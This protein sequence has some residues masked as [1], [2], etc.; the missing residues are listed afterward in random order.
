M[1]Y[2]SI[3]LETT[4]LDPDTCQILEIG[5]VFN[6][7]SLPLALCPIF[8]RL[9]W[10]ASGL[11]KGEAYA[12]WMNAHIIKEI[13]DA[14]AKKVGQD[15]LVNCGSLQYQLA[16]WLASVGYTR[17]EG[18]PVSGVV[19]AGKNFAG[20][21]VRFLR[22]YE[23]DRFVTFKHRVI[24]PGMYYHQKED[25]VPPDTALCL[26][27]ANLEGSVQHR[28][29]DDAKDVIRLVRTHFGVPL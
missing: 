6:D 5:A 27:R 23:V 29:V 3:D 28:A 7:D 15:V 4:G 17:P 21:D 12:L 10:P 11:F 24:D 8:H 19:A 22:R 1:K 25:D 2:V 14:N 20:F 13:H 9:V 16:D 18:K 26:K